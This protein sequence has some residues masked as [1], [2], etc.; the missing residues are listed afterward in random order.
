M[1][2]LCSAPSLDEETPLKH[3]RESGTPVKKK[4]AESLVDGELVDIFCWKNSGYLMQ[5]FA[6]G[7]IY[8]GL[9]A[10]LY[11]FF[12]GYLNVPSYIYSTSS[13]VMLMPWAF[14]FFLGL[15][16]DCV[17]IKGLR[18]KPYMC[19]GWA[20]CTTFLIILATTSMP[21]PYWCV[22]VEGDP[23]TTVIDAQTGKHSAAVPC[24]RHAQHEGGKFALLM[25]FAA[26]GYVIADVAADG[27]TVEFARREPMATRGQTQTTAYLMRTCGQA[28]ATLL[29]GFG[30]NGKQYSGTFNHALS[31]S[32]ICAILAVPSALMVPI[33]WTLVP[34]TQ[35]PTKVRAARSVGM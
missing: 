30:M 19:I 14:K 16:N 29:V 3:D 23:I 10:T 27:L 20:V 35:L 8:G 33:S 1:G 18:R 26:L 28:A 15:L 2:A 11:G 31:F 13:V 9:P 32:S 17:P 5:Y 34:E 21:A 6:V 22:D 25:A 24:N 7:I 12:I 4:E